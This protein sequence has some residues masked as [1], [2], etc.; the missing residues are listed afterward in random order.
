M[1]DAD[2]A[3]VE[4]LSIA[5]ARSGIADGTFPAGSMG[6][7]VRAAV[8]VVDGGGR[9]SIGGLEDPRAVLAGDVGTEVVP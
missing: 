4:R 7:K 5:R 9:A 1:R 8:A 3:P 2:G 6:E